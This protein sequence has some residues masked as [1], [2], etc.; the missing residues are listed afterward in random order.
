MS[1]PIISFLALI[2]L[3]SFYYYMSVATFVSIIFSIPSKR[4]LLLTLFLEII[5]VNLSL[6][7]LSYANSLLKFV[8]T[9][10]ITFSIYLLNLLSNSS[11]CC[12]WYKRKVLIEPSQDDSESS[13]SFPGLFAGRWYASLHFPAAAL[14]TFF[15]WIGVCSL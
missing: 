7:S 1:R 15:F 10:S 14:T 12:F 9:E 3:E 4:T 13:F 8:S 11:N 2:C 5:L 6:T